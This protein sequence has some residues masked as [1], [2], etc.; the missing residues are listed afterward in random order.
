MRRENQKRENPVDGRLPW[1]FSL[2]PN[3]LSE[4]RSKCTSSSINKAFFFSS[5]SFRKE[6]IER[7]ESFLQ[8]DVYIDRKLVAPSENN[9]Q[10]PNILD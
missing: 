1:S 7:K 3:C 5:L 9:G 8:N 2:H 4:S 6:L 10:E